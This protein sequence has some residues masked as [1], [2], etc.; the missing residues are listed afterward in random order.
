M[1]RSFAA[2]PFR[3]A[4]LVPLALALALALATPAAAKGPSQGQRAQQLV[5]QIR[6]SS[7]PEA[8]FLALSQSDQDLVRVALTPAAETEITS[9]LA[10]VPASDTNAVTALAAS[11]CWQFTKTF[12]KKSIIGVHLFGY[13]MTTNWCASGGKI[14]SKQTP[15]RRVYVYAAFWAFVQHLELTQQGGVGSTY[16]RAYTQGYFRLCFP[17]EACVQHAYPWIN[18]T[19]YP[20]GGVFGTM[21]G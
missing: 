3:S 8:A 15:T 13:A 2:T 9:Q 7:D 14:T 21:G 5:D 1:H 10:R 19:M 12:I 16:W 17:F 20:D 6:T 4:L 18:L 11:T